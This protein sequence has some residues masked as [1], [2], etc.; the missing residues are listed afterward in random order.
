MM[1]LFIRLDGLYPIYAQYARMSNMPTLGE[2]TIQF[3][4]EKTKYYQGKIA[5][6]RFADRDTKET[7]N[8]QAW[9]FDYNKMDVN[10]IVSQS[11]ESD[12]ENMK[13]NIVNPFVARM[14]EKGIEEEK[15]KK[16]EDDFKKAQEDL[17][18]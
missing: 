16:E 7:L 5:A 4:L 17:P 2:K 8:H 18:F 3:Y 6:K 13:P 11:V 1:C 9:F 14:V 12:N 10:L 15:L